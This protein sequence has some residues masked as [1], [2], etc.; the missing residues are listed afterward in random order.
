MTT[1]LTTGPIN[2]GGQWYDGYETLGYELDEAG[3]VVFM[4]RKVITEPRAEESQFF[5]HR[6]QEEE[7]A[8]RREFY[9]DLY[10]NF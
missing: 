7:D 3:K 6:R 4:H 1:L 2:S 8:R 10:Y 5:K 9:R